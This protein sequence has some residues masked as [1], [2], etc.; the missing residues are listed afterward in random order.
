MSFALR[1]WQ[2]D[3]LHAQMEE[4]MLQH[5]SLIKEV[6]TANLERK[7]EIMQEIEQLR[8]QRERLLNQI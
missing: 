1:L 5:M 8:Q 6:S 4:I 7:Q 2:D 3:Q